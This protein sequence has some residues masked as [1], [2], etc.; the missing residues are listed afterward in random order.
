MPEAAW[1][2]SIFW[3]Y[4]ILVDEKDY[5]MDSRALLRRLEAAGIQSRPLWQPVHLSRAHAG[6]DY[7]CPA[8]EVL[9]RRALSLPCSVGLTDAQ[10][11]KVIE[12]VRTRPG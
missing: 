4:T 2:T 5:G 1:A 9:Y 8:A 12:H 10:Q 6:H 11:N 3:M 7:A